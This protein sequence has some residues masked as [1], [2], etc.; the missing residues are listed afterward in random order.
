MSLAILAG[1]FLASAAASGYE[2]DPPITLCNPLTI[3]G[4]FTDLHFDI[5]R[6]SLVGTEIRIVPA[7]CGR[8]QAT[9]Q[10]AQGEGVDSEP[11]ALMI[12]DV[13][14]DFQMISL[15]TPYPPSLPDTSDLW[16][17]IPPGTGYA[18]S[19]YGVIFRDHLE[20]LFS[21]ADG[22]NMRVYLPRVEEHGLYGWH[23]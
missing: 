9:V 22:H 7:D 23:P 13:T 10:F 14:E 18:S 17:T 5:R 19:F 12:V 1:M 3:I 16:F 8:Q 11:S 20:G 21:F 6:D 2:A 15:H 4:T